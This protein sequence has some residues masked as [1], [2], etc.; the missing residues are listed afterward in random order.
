MLDEFIQNLRIAV[1]GMDGDVSVDQ[2]S[3]S[4]LPI[5]NFDRVALLDR[6]GRH[7]TQCGG[8]IF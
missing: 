2:I 3:Q 6:N 8:N 4:L 5:G 1:S 7:F